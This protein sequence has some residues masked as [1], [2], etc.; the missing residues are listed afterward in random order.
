[1]E[2]SR[3]EIEQELGDLLEP[4]QLPLQLCVP[5]LGSVPT[6]SDIPRLTRACPTFASAAADGANSAGFT[7]L[8]VPL[9]ASD[10]SNTGAC[11]NR[12]FERG[13]CGLGWQTAHTV[14]MLARS[15]QLR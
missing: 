10:F 4:P 8:R 15:L 11:L 1:M 13:V 5:L 9:G 7:Y 3:A 6:L 14:A 2:G 12:R